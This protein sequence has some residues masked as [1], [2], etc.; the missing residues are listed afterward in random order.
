M[1]KFLG[2]IFNLYSKDL[3]K[4]KFYYYYYYFFY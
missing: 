1:H 2:K 4:L 3:I